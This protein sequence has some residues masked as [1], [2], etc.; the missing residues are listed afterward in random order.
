MEKKKVK[1]IISNI[2]IILTIFIASI[3]TLLIALI[4]ALPWVIFTAIIFL[5][6][7]GLGFVGKIIIIFSIFIPLYI[8]TGTLSKRD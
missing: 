1:E 3:P 8:L 7:S 4:T 6:C 5:I 2:L